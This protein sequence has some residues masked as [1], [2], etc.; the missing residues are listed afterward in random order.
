MQ[1]I[2]NFDEAFMDMY[3]EDKYES[4]YNHQGGE[5]SVELSNKTV[6]FV[7]TESCNLACT[8]CYQCNKTTKAMTKEIAIKAVDM[9]FDES[10]KSDYINQSMI[11]LDFIG[12]EPLIEIELMDFIV[13]YF[14]YKAIIN[15][16]IWMNNYM[17]SISTNGTLYD[18]PRVKD[19]LDRNHG[20]VSFN[21]TIDGNKELHDSCRLYADGRPSYEI[22]EKAVKDV[23]AKNN[24]IGTTK[25][26]LA[27]EN[28]EY[29]LDAIKNLY[30]LNIKHI[31]ANCVYEE[32]WTYD[33]AKVLYIEL[34]KVADYI[35]DNNLI[36]DIYCS[37]FD[38]TLGQPMT[39]EDNQNWCGG[40]GKM[41][42]IGPD[43]VLYPCLRYMSYCLENKERKPISFGHIDTGIGTT[44]EEKENIKCL[45]CI[46][47]K[48]QST[49][50]CYNCS[51][52]SGCAWCS[53]YNYDK[54]GTPNKR[55][56]FVCCTHKARVLA[57]H[58]FYMR[59]FNET[60]THTGYHK[61]LNL[62]KEEALKIISEKEYN[63]LFNL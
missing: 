59:I 45:Q 61:T 6:T 29:L 18:D 20:R 33:H 16:H 55:A 52:G 57:N 10:E 21:I 14:K 12:G 53:G 43:G 13:E 37:L 51:I 26:T 9:L 24:N 17:I 25:L 1:K 62:S 30:S 54:F 31:F 19:F 39:P 23:V 7:V 36:N 50:E 15:N 47:R 8:Y 3:P 34:K 46:T 48:S 28:I 42:A 4:F 35:I 5:L 49:D 32:G 56:T 2:K 44:E 63:M 22:V 60:N 41:L 40:T 27:P 11:I 58:Y 38:E